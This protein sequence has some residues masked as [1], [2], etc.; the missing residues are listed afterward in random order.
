MREFKDKWAASQC[1]LQ[2][3]EEKLKETEYE[4]QKTLKVLT[5]TLKSLDEER[6]KINDLENQ[7]VENV[8]GAMNKERAKSVSC[9]IFYFKEF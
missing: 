9:K 8:G 4:R 2:D 3:T 1:D 6:S 5:K 7:I